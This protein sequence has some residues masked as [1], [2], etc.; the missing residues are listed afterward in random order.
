MRHRVLSRLETTAGSTFFQG[1]LRSSVKAQLVRNL[2]KCVVTVSISADQQSNLIWNK[3][4]LL[5]E[6]ENVGTIVDRQL[7]V[8]MTLGINLGHYSKYSELFE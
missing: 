3:A 7:V 2:C 5:C 1:Q 4:M 8:L 6:E